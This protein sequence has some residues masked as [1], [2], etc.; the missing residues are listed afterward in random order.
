MPLPSTALG[1][2]PK[3]DYLAALSSDAPAAADVL[4]R[5]VGEVVREQVN[6]GID[7]PTDGGLRRPDPVADFVRRLGG[8]DHDGMTE[9]EDEDGIPI[10]LPTIRGPIRAGRDTFLAGHWR[11][12]QAATSRP[13]KV[14]LPG[15]MTISAGLADAFYEGDA[16]VKAAAIADALNREFRMLAVAGC[17]QIQIDEPGM[18]DD[19]AAASAYGLELIERCF[20]RL[21]AGIQRI[22][23]LGRGLPGPFEDP[24]SL[25]AVP[26]PFPDFFRLLDEA[27]VETIAFDHVENGLALPR[28]E[29]F[30]RKRMAVGMLELREGRIEQVEEIAAGMQATLGHIDRDRFI[31]AVGNLGGLPRGQVQAKLLAL[32]EA[33][34]GF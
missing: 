31:A 2:Y 13:V 26:D 18:V 17:R 25:T 16:R 29:L 30:T 7:M 24:G 23:N 3:P 20:F 32:A 8:I 27:P 33:V 4:E 22:V 11:S 21:P 14:P 15:P 34:H 19:L 9:A 12:A 10:L 6:L 28:L 1:T 5:A